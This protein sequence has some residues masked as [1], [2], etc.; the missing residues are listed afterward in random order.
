MPTGHYKRKPMSEE[1]KKK[2]S[3][4]HKGKKFSTEHKMKI[5]EAKKG[6]KRG[7]FWWGYKI[8][9]AQKGKIITKEMRQNMSLAKWQHGRMSNGYLK[10]TIFGDNK[11]TRTTEHRFVMEQHLGRKLTDKEVVH[12]KN[13]DRADNRIE[14]LELMT[15]SEHSRMHRLE[16]MAFNKLKGTV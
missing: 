6:K 9:N 1:T 4:S 16:T 8:S 10:K 2:I 5:S 11:T 13:G 15:W 3:E 7:D 12:H 14:N